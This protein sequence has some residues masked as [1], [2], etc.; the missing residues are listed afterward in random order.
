MASPP[1]TYFISNVLIPDESADEGYGYAHVD[2]TLAG[3][4][5]AAVRFSLDGRNWFPTG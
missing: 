5:I 4:L 1:P 2:V 3:G